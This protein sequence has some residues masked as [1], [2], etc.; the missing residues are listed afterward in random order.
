MPRN[1]ILLFAQIHQRERQEIEA[2][3][4]NDAAKPN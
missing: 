2:I 4:S 3:A 1:K